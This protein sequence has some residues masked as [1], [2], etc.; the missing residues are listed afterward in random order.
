M[1][2]SLE[3]LLGSV[4]ILVTIPSVI[5]TTSFAVA[6]KKRDLPIGGLTIFA[7]TLSF[8][9]LFSIVSIGIYHFATRSRLQTKVWH[10]FWAAA[11]VL[12]VSSSVATMATLAWMQSQSSDLPATIIGATT[13]SIIVAGFV[14][15][16]LSSLTQALLLLRIFTSLR[17]SVLQYR[18]YQTDAETRVESEK[19][20]T[21][22]PHTS[23]PQSLGR[24]SA[25][26]SSIS[27]KNRKR[28]ASDP[29]TSFSLK[30][31][32]RS[33][34]DTMSSVSSGT[35]QRSSSDALSS[36]RSSIGHVV[37][38]I[39]SRTRLVSQ[40]KLNRVSHD[41]GTGECEIVED[42]FDSWDTSAVDPQ[43]RQ[44]FMSPPRSTM[45]SSPSSGRF[46][47]TIP[48]SPTGSRSTS[49]GFPLDFQPPA[50]TQRSRSHSPAVSLRETQ[51]RNS[52]TC[53][54][55]SEAHIHPLFRTDSPTPPP[56]IRAGTVVTAAPGAGQVIL[57]RQSVQKMR[58]GSLRNSPSPL[59]HAKS[60]DDINDDEDEDDDDSSTI[61]SPSPP[62]REMTPP[63][64][65]WVMG[66]GPRSSMAGYTRRKDP[67]VGLNS[68]GETKEM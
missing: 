26:V 33:F 36:I 4:T 47:E 38:P 51:R 56:S 55:A 12:C 31:R 34:S 40:K 43:S 25:D 17:A 21:S 10:A 50:R 7:S 27:S 62:E 46:L 29:R 11:C 45:I 58:S 23:Q 65:D 1:I 16:A 15:W 19:P 64:P 57:D 67:V 24:V 42:G 9:S 44:I 13:Q 37:R 68:V 54:D 18:I 49:P 20:G 6:L 48:A 39:S 22:L 28:S 2:N 35:R 53:P 14:F 52:A 8:L 3:V 30:S 5:L 32:K 60:M 59:G 41:S 66:A 63:I 61:K